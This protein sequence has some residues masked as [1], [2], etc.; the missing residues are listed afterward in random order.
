MPT[1]LYPCHCR[2]SGDGLREL[3]SGTLKK[4]QLEGNKCYLVDAG[5]EVFV[6]FGRI[7]PLDDRRAACVAAE[8]RGMLTGVQVQR[9]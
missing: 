8:V 9:T 4:L 3:G 5:A 2:V 1:P 7:S 6:W